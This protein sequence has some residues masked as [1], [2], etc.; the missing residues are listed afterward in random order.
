MAFRLR[1][2]LTCLVTQPCMV[3]I[4]VQ[5][6]TCRD[7]TLS[8][9]IT[10]RRSSVLNAA[11]VFLKAVHKASTSWREGS[12]LDLPAHFTKLRTQILKLQSA[13]FLDKNQK[14]WGHITM[15]WRNA[16]L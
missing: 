14:E 16:H 11:S 9:A 15:N 4:G 8:F 13:V 10:R 6:N 2:H 5:R 1:Q 3:V 7:C 12:C